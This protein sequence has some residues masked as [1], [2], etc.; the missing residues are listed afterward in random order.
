MQSVEERF[1]P[2]REAEKQ[3]R[4]KKEMKN[5]TIVGLKLESVE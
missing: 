5:V 1:E 3:E 2:K 4:E